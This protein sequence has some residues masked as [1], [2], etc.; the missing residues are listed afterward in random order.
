[1]QAY[2][3]NKYGEV[4]TEGG[5]SSMSSRFEFYTPE[6]TFM[7]DRSAYV[8]RAVGRVYK[9]PVDL[10]AVADDLTKAI[11]TAAGAVFQE[12]AA[13][14]IEQAGQIESRQYADNG[15]LVLTVQF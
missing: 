13:K 4:I 5:P 15:A 6:L 12:L 1:V 11:N 10:Q 9:S 2:L 14:L 8:V 7:V 3:K